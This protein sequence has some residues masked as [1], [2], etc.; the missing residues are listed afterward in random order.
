MNDYGNT[1]LKSV[2]KEVFE[3]ME[4][5][6]TNGKSLLVHCQSGQNRSATIVIAFLMKSYRK[7]LYLSHKELKDL[8]PI[9]QINVK[10]AKQLLALEKELL[11]V[12][13]LPSDWMERS[14]IDEVT[15]EVRYK[16]ENI[17]LTQHDV[18]FPREVDPNV[19]QSK[20]S[21]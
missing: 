5:G 10:Y 8:R 16:H 18:L 11:N 3:F 2:L 9:V 1:D 14:T 17:T 21:L 7:T 4:E 6:Q 19:S 12:N 15:C 13:S 20:G